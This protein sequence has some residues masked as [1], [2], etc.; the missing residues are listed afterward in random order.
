MEE[1]GK[2]GVL[3]VNLG[4]PDAPTR[5]AVYR[6]LKQFLGDPRVIDQWLVRK[7]IVP[8]II[9]PI[10]SGQSAKAY[11]DLWMEEGSPLKIYG[12]RLAEGVQELLG[13]EYA[14][15]LAM[16]YQSPS[17]ESSIKKLLDQ[18]VS[19]LIVL[20]LFPQY[21]SASTGSVQEEVMRLLS[22]EWNI[23]D[24]KIIDKFYDYQPFIDAFVTRGKQYD[25][26]EYDHIL[27]SYHGLPERQIT[28]GDACD[29]CFK[30]GC[31]EVISDK[32]K[33][34]Y[35]AHCVSTT[36]GIA[37]GLGITKDQ[38]TICYQSRL[39]R[40]PWVQPYTSDVIEELAKEG[41]KK[42]LVFCPAFIC[43]CLETTVEISDEYQ[44][45]FEE[46]GGEHLQLVEGLNDHPQWFEAVKDLILEHV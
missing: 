18:R 22:K 43:D 41:K 38:Y 26:A 27:F 11:Q 19:R 10:R 5:G 13:D 14:V 15:E 17:I 25:L 35:K 34:C 30:E 4:T 32:N 44:E 46:L 37:K 39:G 20:P 24:V 1:G 33:L 23:P 2:T 40:D 16:R 28:K 42:I 7:I 8:L 12:Y 6:Y 45:E 21:A 31:C 36:Y 3:L 29:H 9:L